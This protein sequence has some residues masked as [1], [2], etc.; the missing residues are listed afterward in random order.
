MSYSWMR[1]HMRS[2]KDSNDMV[3]C[4]WPS[5]YKHTFHLNWGHNNGH[6]S[7]YSI[8]NVGF[9]GNRSRPCSRNNPGWKALCHNHLVTELLNVKFD[10]FKHNFTTSSKKNQFK[11]KKY[12][13][14]SWHEVNIITLPSNRID[15]EL[16]FFFN[17]RL[18]P[19]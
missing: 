8:R 5:V 7:S 18:R 17:L 12:N 16:Y 6:H 19:R 1:P 15:S 3:R 9:Q 14:L 2:Q 11:I 13:Y 10:E 4:N